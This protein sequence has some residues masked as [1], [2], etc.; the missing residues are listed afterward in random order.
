MILLTIFLILIIYFVID[1]IRIL[2]YWKN[3]N[4]KYLTPVPFLGSYT[5]LVFQ[6]QS[7]LDII[8]EMYK[9]F[10]K[11]R[12]VGVY[13]FTQPVLMVRDLEL[14]KKIT[15]K[16]F[17]SF[18]D[19]HNVFKEDVDP[20]W[21]KNLFAS[22]G[23]RWRSLRQTLS[24]VFTSSKM[25]RMFKLM[26][27]VS[28][29][30]VQHIKNHD[31]EVPEFEAA[32]FFSKFTMDVIATT[33]FGLECNSLEDEEFLTQG[34]IL[35]DFSGLKKFKIFLAGVHPVILKALGIKVVDD[36]PGTY[37]RKIIMETMEYR[38]K[39]NII[40]PDL[41]HLLMEARKGKLKF[42]EE[43]EVNASFSQTKEYNA[44]NTKTLR[45]IDLDDDDIT[46][47]TLV[48][49]FGGYDTVKI[50]MVFMLYELLM[51]P[52]VQDKLRKEMMALREKNE[53]KVTYE[54]LLGLKY[55]DMVVSETLRLWPIAAFIDRVCNKEYTIEPE[56]PGEE[57]LV[58]E[59]GISV[60]VPVG[61]I[62]MDPKYWPNP[63][64]FDPE[65][66]NEENKHK[67]QPNTYLP[68]GVGPRN[69]IGS[70][71]ALVDTKV[72]FYHLMTN[73]E[74]VTTRNTKLPAELLKN[75]MNLKIK[76]GLHFGLKKL[77]EN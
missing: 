76:G 77:N 12:Y 55:L 40:R 28:I 52:E 73:F 2:N 32:D 63:T 22:E 66:F 51:N 47:Q 44:G 15:I 27:D 6:T 20:L 16:D 53:G 10:P 8:Q 75:E 64:K 49:F 50:L 54:E 7:F 57:K 1:Y 9:K 41:V 70:R 36:R 72:F 23:E 58:L 65:R 67:I 45:K 14:I 19:H 18:L 48:F 59:K 33:A 30:Y 71:Y 39:H 69:C 56:N 61:G 5:K 34:R 42:E 17:D 43:T 25:R 38:E 46:A 68:F 21:G 26:D 13:Q 35:T 4:V 3:K 24:P 37:F 11:E 62:Q 60:M 29:K 31:E 74:I